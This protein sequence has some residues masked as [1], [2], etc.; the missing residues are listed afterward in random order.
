MNIVVTIKQVEDPIIPP[1]HMMLDSSG[2]RA[3]S[4]SR[5]PQVMN[6][7]DANALEE[8]ICLKHKQ[9]G[10]I[11]AICLGEDSAKKTLKRAIAMGA[12]SGILLSDPLW[13]ELDGSGIASVLA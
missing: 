4:A 11:T 10:K 8:A 5:A 7:Y 3:M 13:N 9:G 12:D 1:S 2:K 6:G